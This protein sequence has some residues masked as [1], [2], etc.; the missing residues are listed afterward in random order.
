MERSVEITGETP[1]LG[2]FSIKVLDGELVVA[3]RL[4]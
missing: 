3:L 4:V 1:E 2:I